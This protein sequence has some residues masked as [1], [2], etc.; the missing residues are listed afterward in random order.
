M[1]YVIATLDLLVAASVLYV[2]L[3]ASVQIDYP[4]FLAVYLLAVIAALFSQVPGGLGVLE[5]VLIVLL[6]PD[7]PQ[8]VVGALLAYRLIYYLIPLSLGVLVLGGHELV[9]HR[10]HVGRLAGLLGRWTAFVA[11][12]I[13]TVTIFAAGV[14]LL[15]SG[16]TPVAHGRLHLLRDMLPLPVIEISHLLGSIFGIL[17]ILLAHSVQRRVETA[18]YAVVVLLIGGIA[19]SLLKGLDYE[20]AIV[21]TVMLVIF[22]PCRRHFYRKGAILTERFSARWFAAIGIVI[23]CTLWLMLFAYK[24][25][26]YNDQLWWQFAFRGNAPR[27]LR[28]MAG[29]VLVTLVF[30]ASR[31]L[32]SKS[33]PPN[34]PTSADL[35]AARQIV[36]ASPYTA[37]HLAML[38]DK[39]LLFNSERTAFIM[40]GVEGRS[41]IAMGDPVGEEQARRGLIWDFQ[42]LCDEGGRWPVFYQVDL[43]N[44][45]MYAELGLPLI[46]LGEEARV[47]LPEFGL[48]GGARKN[49]RRTNKQLVDEG[50]TFEIVD[51]PLTDALLAELKQ[52]SDAWLAEKDTAEKGFSLGFFQPQYIRRSPVALVRRQGELIAFANIWQGAG[53]SELSMDLMRYLPDAPQ[54]VMEYLLIQLMLWGKEQGYEWFNLGMAPLSGVEAQPLAPLWNRIAAIAYRHGEQFYN[55]QG[56][57]QY[58]DK[59]DPEWTPKYLASPGGLALPIILTNVAA[60][61]SGGLTQVVAK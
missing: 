33:K 31:L 8:H 55:F 40:Y 57:R 28:A 4:H 24:H 10:R 26:E 27:S 17:L 47:L 20:E 37:A 60:L 41:W 23:A 5:L 9:L 21:L 54:G 56:L 7:E 13:L 34:A 1:Q 45:A 25:V 38:G 59:F 22:L 49:L 51:P 32:R 53:R 44:V 2:L 19:F 52:I 12:R 61:I 30:L 18:Y 39:H 42:E 11:P 48:E 43:D 6:S 16:A 35:D 14:V 15:L 58:K 50:C 36:A 3:P 46:K 29:V